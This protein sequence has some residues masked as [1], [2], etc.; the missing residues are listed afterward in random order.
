M[1]IKKIAKIQLESL[2]ERL[3][4]MDLQLEITDAALAEIARIG[5]D[6]VFGARPL[7]RAIQSRIENPL[8]KELLAG[9]FMPNDTVI[10]DSVADE[11]V[12]TK[13][14]SEAADESLMPKRWMY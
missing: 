12:I 6:P 4:K 5:Y 11:L 9:K 13:K 1:Q 7:K 2:K 8:A 14:A 3:A 10:I